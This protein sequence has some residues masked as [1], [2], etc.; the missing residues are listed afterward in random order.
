VLAAGQELDKAVLRA[1]EAAVPAAAV[2][3]DRRA[4]ADAAIEE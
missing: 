2:A 4:P 1:A 3:G